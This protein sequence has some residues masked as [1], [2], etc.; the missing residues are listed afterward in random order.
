MAD[1]ALFVQVKTKVIFTFF[2]YITWSKPDSFPCLY[3]GLCITFVFFIIDYRKFKTF[4]WLHLEQCKNFYF[5]EFFFRLPLYLLTPLTRQEGFIKIENPQKLNEIKTNGFQNEFLGSFYIISC[6]ALHVFRFL[7]FKWLFFSI[8]L[9]N[10]L[11]KSSYIN[12][13]E[14]FRTNNLNITELGILVFISIYIY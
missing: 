11:K 14:I 2:W 1:P 7:F 6:L 3:R 12:F 9:K 10:I 13:F 5:V 4:A 8:K